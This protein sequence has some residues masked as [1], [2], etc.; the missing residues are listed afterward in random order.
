MESKSKRFVYVLQSL[1]NPDRH[2]T[3]VTSDVQ[4]RLA[5]HN[6]G[7]SVHTAAGRPW[8]INVVLEFR[9]QELALKF[10]KYLKS[11]S[12]RAFSRRHF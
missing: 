6:K 3:G 5:S 2:Y 1:S 7:A 8:Q 9:T 10:E 12:G 4:Q 11:G